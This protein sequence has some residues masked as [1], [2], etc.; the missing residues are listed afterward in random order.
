MAQVPDEAF[1]AHG[2]TPAQAV[3]LRTVFLNWADRLAPESNPIRRD[4]AI[5]S[6]HL[7]I[8]YQDAQTALNRMAH[9]PSMTRLSDQQLSSWRAEAT[10]NLLHALFRPGRAPS[11]PSSSCSPSP[12]SWRAAPN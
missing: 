5:A 3:E 12:A 9:S 7:P 4:T 6:G 8:T 1:A 11:M 2:Y 10:S